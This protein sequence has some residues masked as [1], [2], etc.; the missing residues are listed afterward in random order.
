MRAHCVFRIKGHNKKVWGE[1][2]VD[3]DNPNIGTFTTE[4]E[5]DVYF[6]G[7]ANI[8]VPI[9]GIRNVFEPQGKWKFRTDRK[10]HTG[11][12]YQIKRVD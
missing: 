3:P 6:S 10:L 9:R 11:T 12:V 5:T 8:L 2:E 1:F 7:T 4:Y